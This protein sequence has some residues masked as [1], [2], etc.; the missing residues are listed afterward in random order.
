MFLLLFYYLQV[1]VS[2]WKAL[3]GEEDEIDSLNSSGDEICEF[4]N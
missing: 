1:A 3:G 2:F 4:H